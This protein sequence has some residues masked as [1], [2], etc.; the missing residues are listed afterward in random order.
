[1]PTRGEPS[2]VMA[3]VAIKFGILIAYC[4]VSKMIVFPSN[5]YIVSHRLD[6]CSIHHTVCSIRSLIKSFSSFIA[7]VNDLCTDVW[8]FKIHVKGN[9]IVMCWRGKSLQILQRGILL[10]TKSC[11]EAVANSLRNFRRHCDLYTVYTVT[12]ILVSA[13]VDRPNLSSA[14]ISPSINVQLLDIKFCFYERKNYTKVR[15]GQWKK[16]PQIPYRTFD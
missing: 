5:I 13:S 14:V 4:L 15:Q 11:S 10:N 8:T 9:L 2:V 6:P 3:G 16:S 12:L 7:D 1:M